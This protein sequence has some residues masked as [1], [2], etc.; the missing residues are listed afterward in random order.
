MDG[1]KQTPHIVILPSP[2]M[3]HLIPLVEF[4]KKFV[5]AHDFSITFTIPTDG[6]STKAQKEALDSLPNCI[7]TVFLSPV[8]LDDLSKDAKVETRI[9][10]T[11]LRSLPSL[12]ESLKVLTATTSIAALVVD[13]FGTDA[14][15]VARKFNVPSYIFFPTT[16]MVL[17]LYLHLPKL[18]ELHSWE[19]RDLPEPIKLPGCVPLRGRDLMDSLQHRQS[20]V[21]TWT[22]Y[23][24]KRFKLADGILLNSFT[25]M[26]AGAI[27]ALKEGGDPS[28]PPIYPIGPLTQNG[29]GDGADISG[30]LRWLNNQP[31]N[32]V[33]FVS[34]GSGGALSKEQLNELA[35][36]L[37]LSEQRFLWVVKSPNTTYLGAQSTKED[38]LSFLPKGFLERTKGRGLVVPSWAPQIQVLSHVST[39]GFLTHCGWNSSLESVVH[40]V[41]LIVWPLHAEQKMNAVML[42]EDL[43]VALRPKVEKNGRVGRVEIA[44]VVKCLLEG[45][46]GKRIQ[47][48]MRILKNATTKVL[49]EEG[50]S[51][52]LLSEVA[53]KWKSHVGI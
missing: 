53:D 50:S 43:K 16:A 25:E 9:Y 15:D 41:P 27:K 40:G 31:T 5:H 49:S 11:I 30:C 45:D 3:G 1:A 52:K 29:S 21:Y 36:G 28:V 32:S 8:N 35:L 38:P 10:L 34:F 42:V 14:F 47:N 33:L 46:K 20:K 24:S 13:L 23:H 12:R 26:E 6:S 22:L 19:Y 4:A 51:R 17:S 37:E 44:R 18:N 7:N 2:G 48:R 39:G